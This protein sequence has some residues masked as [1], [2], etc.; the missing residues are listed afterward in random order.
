MKAIDE[1]SRHMAEIIGVIDGIA[2]QTNLLALNAAVEAARAGEAGR[3]F[4]VVAEEVRNLAMRAKDAARQTAERIEASVRSAESGAQ[5][6]EQ[7]G[8]ALASIGSGARQVSALISEIA[9]SSEKQ[10]AG[11]GQ[12]RQGASTVNASI[13]AS[14]A[15]TEQ[16]AAAAHQLEGQAQALRE[17]VA[18]YQL[19]DGSRAPGARVSG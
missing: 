8:Q 11:V 13:Q 6:G 3:G 9:G 12:L 18:T 15:S 16:S 7:L 2:F 19:S 10:S 4:A 14:A 17:L 1:S 5:T